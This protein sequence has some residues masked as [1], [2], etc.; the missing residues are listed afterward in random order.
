M[1]SMQLGS[2][3]LTFALGWWLGPGAREQEPAQKSPSTEPQQPAPVPGARPK[4]AT[5][6]VY[7]LRRRFLRAV[8]DP[9]PATGYLAITGRHLF[10][11]VAEPG[12][13]P[14]KPLLRAG[15]RS[16]TLEKDRTKLKVLNG[17]LTDGE[18]A[19][20]VERPGLEELR[21]IELIQGGLRIKQDETS[22]LEFERIE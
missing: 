21:A 11:C 19:I 10:L 18:G 15:V 7:A 16:W 2:V 4:H 3:V 20:V 13:D 14:Q 5:E 1:K 17:W 6:G 9:R 8:A 22:W 12:P